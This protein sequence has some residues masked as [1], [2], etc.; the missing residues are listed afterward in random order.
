MVNKGTILCYRLVSL[1][2]S[3]TSLYFLERTNNGIH[4]RHG[5]AS[6]ALRR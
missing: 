4:E 1:C 2:N 3:V 5:E 6:D